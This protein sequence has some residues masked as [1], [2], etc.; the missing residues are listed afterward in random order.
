MRE[1]KDTVN[2]VIKSLNYCN[3]VNLII[4]LHIL[5]YIYIYNFEYKSFI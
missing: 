1:I 5:T 2:L 4:E 3:T